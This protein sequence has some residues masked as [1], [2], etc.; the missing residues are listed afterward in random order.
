M[1]HFLVDDGLYFLSTFSLTPHT[2]TLSLPLT[3]LFIQ[4][5][6][7][8]IA[9]KKHC[10]FSVTTFTDFVYQ[11]I[12][13]RNHRQR[14]NKHKKYTRIQKIN[15]QL[16]SEQTKLNL[17]VRFS[18]GFFFSLAFFPRSFS[19][20]SN[21][22][23]PECDNRSGG[24]VVSSKLSLPLSGALSTTDAMIVTR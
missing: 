12:L 4:L 11:G 23:L 3:C 9:A 20:S 8:D 13:E 14:T 16:I 6:A 21:M 19:A 24:V 10:M 7:S 15:C 18:E 17:A 2:H 1:S 5:C 22:N